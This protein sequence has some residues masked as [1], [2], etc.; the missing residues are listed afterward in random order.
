MISKKGPRVPLYINAR[1]ICM[2][3]V[4]GVG[5]RAFD[6]RGARARLGILLIF[7]QSWASKNDTV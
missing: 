2:R 5:G 3:V 1:V 6:L 4:C 7:N